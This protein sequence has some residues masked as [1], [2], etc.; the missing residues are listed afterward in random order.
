MKQL[1]FKDIA[2]RELKKEEGKKRNYH[3]MGAEYQSNRK[4]VENGKVALRCLANEWKN[5]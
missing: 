5:G 2:E 1:I 4:L 3:A